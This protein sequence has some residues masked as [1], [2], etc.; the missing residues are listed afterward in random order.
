MTTGEH[1]VEYLV[2]GYSGAKPQPPR[3]LTVFNNNWFWSAVHDMDTTCKP[4]L[5]CYVLCAHTLSTNRSS[6]CGDINAAHST[7]LNNCCLPFHT[8]QTTWTCLR[9]I[10]GNVWNTALLEKIHLVPAVKNMA[11][12]YYYYYYYSRKTEKRGINEGPPMQNGKHIGLHYL[13][14][15]VD[16]WW[17]K[18]CLASLLILRKT[19]M[20]WCLF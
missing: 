20:R 4:M 10:S 13:V 2:G 6:E 17:V 1:R 11:D 7:D 5:N 14:Q 12:C 9:G 15:E 3:V 19:L 16:R 18:A 8:Q